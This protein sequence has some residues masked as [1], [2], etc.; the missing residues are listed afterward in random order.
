MT[1]ATQP[2]TPFSEESKIY[3]PGE[4]DDV[5]ESHLAGAKHIRTNRKWGCY[6]VPCAFD[7]ETTSF[8]ADS[9]KRAIMYGWTL[10]LNGGVILGRTWPEFV[11]CID[12]II[13]KMG[14]AP[15]NRLIVYVHNLGYEFQFMR[16]WF[17]WDDVFALSERK[18]VYARTVDGVEFRCS[19]I[20]TDYNLEKLGDMLRTYRVKKMVG[21]L[22]YSLYR[23]SSTPLTDKEIG[24]MV[25]D[26]R[27]VMAYIQEQIDTEGNITRIPLT[28]TGYVRRYCRN[29]CLYDG[30]SHK[31][32]YK[33]IQ[34]R[35]IMDRLQL[36]SDE[37][38]QLRRAFQ[39]GF[40]HANAFYAERIMH[41]VESYDFT[42]SYPTVMVAEKFPMGRGEIVDIRS[43][44]ELR[45]NL[46]RYCCLFDVEFEGLEAA[47]LTDHPLSKSKCWDICNAIEDNGRIVSADSVK[48]TITDIDFGIL[49]K[50]YTWKSLSIG[51]FRRYARG[52]LPTD[53]VR[54][55]LELYRTKTELKGVDGREEEY[56]NAKERINACYGMCVTDICRDDIT[57][58]RDTWSSTSPDID[59]K[60]EKENTSRRRFLFYA[61]G[62]WVT[63]YAR[64]NLFEG[65]Y[66]CA[67]D[68]IY[69]DTDSIKITNP[70]KHYNF[71]RDYNRKIVE[72]LNAACQYHDIDP[73]YIRPK[74]IKG[75]EKPLGVWDDEGTY[76]R[77]KTLGAKRY[78]TEKE[79][80]IS[81]TVSGVN[82]KY[83]VPYLTSKYKSRVF[84][85]FADELEIPASATGKTTHTYLDDE[86][87]GEIVDY[88]GKTDHYYER[89][90][91]HLEPAAYCMSMS[92]VYVDYIMGIKEYN[93]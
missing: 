44:A 34:Y 18:P 6:N 57:Y 9:E 51:T 20:L 69:A 90:A 14:I 83:A 56:V 47:T 64:R 4:I 65:I 43:K 3:S 76:S 86:M 5:I 61:W 82:K 62:V 35:K 22:D 10:G 77:F 21:D 74:T 75:V 80:K 17:E 11:A 89:S 33:Y 42:S 58:S 1:K 71:I 24:Y 16:K 84:D 30:K 85:A 68:Y 45:Y 23:H 39:G 29:E 28:K 40:T 38:L 50:F 2:P 13:E 87:T 48:T 31:T 93:K 27:V 73:E 63:A 52:Y 15:D 79:G 25:N 54:S 53:F 49:D 78:M 46:I 88:L 41:D 70:D 7:I 66:E 67:D 91:I 36:T 37:Y 60:I 19:Y 12:R 59:E 81:I 92:A 26:V 55:I 8:Y 32:P 72:K